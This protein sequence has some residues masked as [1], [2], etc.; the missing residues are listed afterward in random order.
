MN[1]ASAAGPSSDRRKRSLSSNGNDVN[2][3]MGS[4]TDAASVD[5]FTTKVFLPESEL[6]DADGQ[7][8][9]LLWQVIPKTETTGSPIS[10][11][12]D[13]YGEN[14]INPTNSSYEGPFAQLDQVWTNF[15]R[16]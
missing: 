13:Y 2:S 1:S 6:M 10:Y 7:T 15:G 9:D 14:E 11:G 5:N 3:R 12:V 16:G 8:E 4:L